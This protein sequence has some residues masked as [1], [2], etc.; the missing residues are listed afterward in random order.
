MWCVE[1][2]GIWSGVISLQDYLIPIKG[3]EMHWNS[4]KAKNEGILVCCFWVQE[5]AYVGV[6][7][8]DGVCH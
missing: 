5:G 8:L 4:Q 1:E 7:Y 3:M 2:G 6:V